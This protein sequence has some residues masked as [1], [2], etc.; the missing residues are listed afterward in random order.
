M[1][2]GDLRDEGYDPHLFQRIKLSMQ[3]SLILETLWILLCIALLISL[4]LNP[5]NVGSN[6]FG[7]LGLYMA[8]LFA[9]YIFNIYLVAG[10]YKRSLNRTLRM[11]SLKRMIKPIVFLIVG[12]C[13]M[14]AFD[15]LR[16]YGDVIQNR[17]FILKVAAMIIYGYIAIYTLLGFAVIL[18]AALSI[19]TCQINI[20]TLCSFCCYRG[21]DSNG[22]RRRNQ[23]GRGGRR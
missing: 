3:R 4:I 15:A 20:C 9:F 12:L 11:Q 6:Y 8:C 23:G 2:R 7:F 21:T 17:F 18:L 14:F 1:R 5:E 19:L 10:I 16:F 22:R 13:M